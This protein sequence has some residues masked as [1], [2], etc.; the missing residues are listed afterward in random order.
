[1]VFGRLRPGT[2]IE[3]ALSELN[4]VQVRISLEIPERLELRA[5]LKPLQEAIVGNSRLGLLVVMGAVAAVLLVLCVNLANL[6]F[7]RAAGRGQELAVRVAL[8]ASRMSLMRQLLTESLV[9]SVAAVSSVVSWPMP[10]S[11]FCCDSH[12][13]ICRALRRS[14]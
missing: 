5:S 1:M 8:G 14:M 11:A 13:S 7:A 10:E 2:S 12:L 9:L 3:K 4:V 6:W